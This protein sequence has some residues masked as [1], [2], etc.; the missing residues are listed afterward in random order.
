MEKHQIIKNIDD[1]KEQYFIASKA[2][3]VALQ[4][5]DYWIKQLEHDNGSET[6]RSDREEN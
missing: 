4:N 1:A 2:L 3:Q 6:I 5:L